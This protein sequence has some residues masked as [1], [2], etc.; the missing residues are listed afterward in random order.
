MTM[1]PADII[2]AIL[3]FVLVVIT[4]Y[5]AYQARRHANLLSEQIEENRRA[6]VKDEKIQSLDRIANW[7]TAAIDEL[8][9]PNTQG[10]EVEGTTL[11]R[12]MAP[13]IARGPN[14]AAEAMQFN[15]TVKTTVKAAME[16]LNQY[17][18][19]LKAGKDI[20]VV[21]SVLENLTSCLYRVIVAVSV[22]RLEL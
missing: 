19:V 5:Y 20:A 18:T 11:R 14:V 1:Q 8:L 4:G 16:A 22:Q 9:L 2:Q 6:R 21:L 10:P 7:A 12:R 15:E 17:E 13:F 3:V